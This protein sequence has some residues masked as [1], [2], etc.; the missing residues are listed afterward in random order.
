MSLAVLIVL[1]THLSVPSQL[2]PDS[3]YKLAIALLTW[4][5]DSIVL[6]SLVKLCVLQSHLPASLPTPLWNPRSLFHWTHPGLILLPPSCMTPPTLTESESVPGESHRLTCIA[7]GFTF[8][9]YAMVWVRQAPGKGLEWIAYIGTLGY[10]TYYSQSVQGRFTISRDDSS[11]K[12][13]LQ[14]NGLKT[15]DTAVYYC[16]RRDTVRESS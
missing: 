11:S 4:T 7:S 13:Y 10:P 5:L 15:E 1:C 16:A 3:Q 14:M 6:P 9:S 12:L 2:F 8:S